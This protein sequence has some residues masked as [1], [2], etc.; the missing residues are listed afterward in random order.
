MAKESLRAMRAFA[1]AIQSIFLS[2]RLGP[3]KKPGEIIEKALDSK[4]R[5]DLQGL[6]SDMISNIRLEK[7]EFWNP[8]DAAFEADKEEFRK[9]LR[10][11][12]KEI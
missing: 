4:K 3:D 2:S 9:R 10:D 12:G 11:A 7:W 6:T 8:R 1:Y 5:E